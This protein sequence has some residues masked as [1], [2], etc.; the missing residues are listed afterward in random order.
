MLLIP[1]SKE[2]LAPYFEIFGILIASAGLI[3]TVVAAYHL[4]KNLTP[5]PC[6]K[7]NA[8]LVQ[9]GLY[10]L[11]RHPIYF[12]VLL[13]ALG[14]LLIYPHIWILLEVFAL[15][16]FFDVKTRREEKWLII[17]FPQYQDYQLK[18]KKLIP[19]IY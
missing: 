19:G 1:S 17:R 3:F 10:R 9:S 14:F 15:V 5:L 8:Q 11:V 18:V 4:G 16:L 13:V 12:G 7:E 6:P 2:F